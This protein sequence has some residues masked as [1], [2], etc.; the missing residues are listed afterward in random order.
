MFGTLTDAQ[1]VAFAFVFLGM[2]LICGML[3]RRAVPW[4]AAVYIPPSVLAGFLIL[5]A[6]PQVLGELTDDWSLVPAQIIPV[7]STL[8]GLLINV[9][10]GGI[11]IGK[12][13]PSMRRIWHDAAPHAI[14]GSVFSFGQFAI[15]GLTVTFLLT[16]VFG[17]PDAAGSIIEMSFAGGHGSIAGMGP[18]LVDAG[19]GELVDVGLGLATISMLTGVIGGTVLVNWAVRSPRVDVAREH[20]TTRFTAS[21]LSDVPPNEGDIT[22]DV[23]IGSIS[24][25]FGAIAVAIFIG[26]LILTALRAISNAFGSDLFDRFPL[27]PFTVI[28]GFIVQLVLSWTNHEHF[29]ERRTVND[30]TGLSLDLLIAAAVGTLSLSTL[31]ANI[32][33]IVILTVLSVAWSVAGLLWLGPRFF[34]R[35]WFDRGIAD[36]GQSQGNVATG[37]ILAEMTDPAHTTGAATGYGYKQ[38]FY[39]PFLGGGILTAMSVPLILGVGS[40]A[41]GIASAATT[42]GLIIWGVVRSR[43]ARLQPGR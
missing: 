8:P 31:G 12:T 32:P 23:A 3:L 39:E 2:A 27:F 24:R 33:S 17:L 38:L 20:T 41:F 16:P 36:Y 25:S 34:T 9:V 22:D 6:G 37:F 29:V 13:L 5:F 18:L 15:G 4:L 42:V 11:M 1:W 30:I 43:P 35:H 14:L 10:F 19:A 28:G 26:F 21:R 7:L 40:L